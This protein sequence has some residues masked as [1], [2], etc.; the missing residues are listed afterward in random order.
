MIQRV[1]QRAMRLLFKGVLIVVGMSFISMI[2][3]AQGDQD[4]NQLISQQ[5]DYRNHIQQAS[6]G[7]MFNLRK[8]VLAKAAKYQ[9][10]VLAMEKEK[11]NRELVKAPVFLNRL[12]RSNRLNTLNQSEN[13]RKA[14]EDSALF[15]PMTHS[16][17]QAQAMPQA[18]EFVSFSM[19]DIA[20][21]QTLIQAHQLH[22]PVVIRGLIRHSFKE[23]VMVLFQLTK[24]KNIDG[25][26]IDPLWFRTFHIQ[27]VPALVLL[28]LAPDQAD[29]G[30]LS[31]GHC[32]DEK[33]YDVVYG[34][35][36]ISKALVLIEQHSGVASS[37]A[38]RI[39]DQ[40]K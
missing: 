11:N 23:T 8:A 21:Q 34:T 12:N 27:Q 28:A 25:V 4:I 19:P 2:S 40:G 1:F 15:T 38:K 6:E 37:M 26:L 33:S 35:I 14:T 22:I 29:S 31:A 17:H 16:Y 5:V 13:S 3:F 36:P 7:A 20:L 24:E 32:D 10:E 9:A 18:I 39:L 30:C